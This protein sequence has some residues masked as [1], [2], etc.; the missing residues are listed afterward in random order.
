VS[1]E[2]REL[3]AVDRETKQE[4]LL[5]TAYLER[6][7]FAS[8]RSFTWSPDGKWIAYLAV[9]ERAF[10]NV[11]VVSA[12]GGESRQASFLANAFSGSGSWSPDSQNVLFNTHQRTQDGRQARGAPSPP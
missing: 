5:A 10:T 2:G 7:P 3:R 11:S 6:R 4:R 9:G 12:A 8:N 1:G